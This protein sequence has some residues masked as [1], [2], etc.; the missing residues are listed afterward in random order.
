LLEDLVVVDDSS[1]VEDQLPRLH[2]LF[3]QELPPLEPLQ[4]TG[5]PL[6]NG[7]TVDTPPANAVGS[8]VDAR[9]ILDDIW[10]LSKNLSPI[11]DDIKFL[12]WQNFLTQ[13]DQ[14]PQPLYLSE[15][16][17][18]ILDAALQNAVKSPRA[19]KAG[20]PIHN[21]I[22]LRSLWQLGL[23]RASV[24][25]PYNEEK[26]AFEQA[27]DDGKASGAT[28]TGCQS[29]IQV[30]LR[31]GNANLKLSR[32]VE[33][34]YAGRS[35]L[36]V[37]VA[38]ARVVAAV[39]DGVE[40]YV[41]ER[42]GRIESLIQIQTLFE[43]P[44]GLIDIVTSIV[45]AAGS[46]ET[47]ETLLSVIFAKA[48][49]FE[50][51]ED[52][53]TL[54]GVILRVV[55]RPWLDRL[56]QS[57]GLTNKGHAHATSAPPGLRNDEVQVLPD[58]VHE[59]ERTEINETNK[60]L[61]YLQE[62][63]PDHHLL[64]SVEEKLD[65]AFSWDDIDR[66]TRK[67][68]QH[69]EDLKSALGQRT[70][71]R[72]ASSNNVALRDASSWLAFQDP[73]E[74]AYSMDMLDNLPTMS[75]HRV[76]ELLEPISSFLTSS[77]F[78]LDLRPPL[79]LSFHL[80]TR[81][82]LDIQHLEL[83]TAALTSITQHHYLRSHLNLLHSFQFFA[84]GTFSARLSAALLNPEAELAERRKNKA[85]SGGTNMGLKLGSG[86]RREWPPASSELRLA[87]MGIL[88][89]SW[90]AQSSDSAALFSSSD[91][92]TLSTAE[93][94]TITFTS[95]SGSNKTSSNISDNLSFSL[96]TDLAPADIDRILDP[97]SIYALDFLR[98]TYTP[99]Q[100]L[101]AIFT[102]STLDSYD[103]V[104]RLLLRLLR[105]NFVLGQ[106]F[107]DTVVIARGHSAA[108][109]STREH[110]MDVVQCFRNSASH[111]MQTITSVFIMAG[112][113]RPWSKLL[114]YVDALDGHLVGKQSARHH[115]EPFTFASLIAAHG[116]A[117]ETITASLLLRSKQRKAA[118]A[119]ESVLGDVLSFAKLLRE[120]GE[121]RELEVEKSFIRYR[122]HVSDFVMCCRVGLDRKASVGLSVEIEAGR[123]DADECV[124][125][126]VERLEEGLI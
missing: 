95:G 48:Q 35:S 77:R 111:F 33:K 55:S 121:K 19:T 89:D 79:S 14:P 53:Q 61:G 65:W 106:I 100:A 115:H 28:L 122:Q 126:I 86:E 5:N 107:R 50:Q 3:L 72:N 85:R 52:M 117:L 116:I 98:L 91:Q 10:D 60:S 31:L 120:G 22:L 76:D 78:S 112:V 40:V 46:A 102:T 42:A 1:R 34:T 104:F 123:E 41:V 74:L 43:R 13:N 110:G 103:R 88:T 124:R 101:R 59:E 113:E 20:R 66:I 49:D 93:T 125:E 44:K 58:F 27:I 16:G 51:I 99:P 32:F 56:Q 37:R 17:S 109:R 36:P 45:D 68:S 87:L 7:H 71:A 15:A 9:D 105:V 67:A 108:R 96:R 12:T 73:G 118:V 24:I 97:D 64:A 82:L 2:G 47:D 39:R 6:T 38:L 8:S 80:S 90:Q 62:N 57:I 25:F 54:L 63:H 4:P 114:N 29:L 92:R 83:T 69:H 26:H 11:R 70:S 94:S 81:P 84:S 30:F 21:S 23:G 18:A 119:L 75:A